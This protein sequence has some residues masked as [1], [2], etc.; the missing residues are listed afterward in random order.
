MSAS[1]IKELENEIQSLH[2][3][4][5]ENQSD[6]YIKREELKNLKD[7]KWEEKEEQQKIKEFLEKAKVDLEKWSIVE[8]GQLKNAYIED[9]RV[10]AFSNK[11]KIDLSKYNN[12][13]TLSLL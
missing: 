12:F 9:T 1:K 2:D 3:S 7:P 4:I 10:M 11:P 6:L 8:S 5:E 13:Q